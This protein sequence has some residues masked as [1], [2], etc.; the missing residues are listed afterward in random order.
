M[1][2]NASRQ[3]IGSTVVTTDWTAG[4]RLWFAPP[5]VAG[6][7]DIS[8][9]TA[10]EA[11]E[12]SRIRGTRKQCDWK[13]SRLLLHA[14]GPELTDSRSLAHSHGYAALAIGPGLT[15][16]GVDIEVLS[17]RNFA[18]IAQL[19]YGSDE[20]D[21]LDSLADE[22]RQRSAFYELWTL[23]E[24][25]IKALGLPLLEG[26]RNCRFVDQDGLWNPWLPTTQSWVAAT[27]MPTPNVILSVVLTGF[28]SQP[29]SFRPICIEWPDRPVSWPAL[30][31]ISKLA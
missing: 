14:A 1:P 11:G 30:R 10:D 16:V 22:T 4:V 3:A 2:L 25:S 13:A 21:W 29:G 9:L 6:S 7:L 28:S 23:K 26:L 17:E 19:A 27:F 12:F 20:S 24:A 8:H 15:R 5:E 31:S 18:A